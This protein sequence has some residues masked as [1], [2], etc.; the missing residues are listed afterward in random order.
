MKTLSG[1]FAYKFVVVVAVV[2]MTVIT[3]RVFAQGSGSRPVPSDR[4]MTLKFKEAELKDDTGDTFKRVVK[5]LKGDQFSV[6]LKHKDGSEEDVTPASGASLKIDKVTKSE[7]A[8]SSDGE[9]TA[10]GMHVTQSV[11][12]DSTAEIQ[13]VLDTLK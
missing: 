10:I 5:A 13:G 6:K 3:I 2:A 11:T 9:F 8:K 7:L 4:K 12:S 1:T